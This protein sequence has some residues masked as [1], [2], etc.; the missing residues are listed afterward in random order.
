MN[1]KTILLF[2]LIFCQTSLLMAQNPDSN[3]GD[4]D[5]DPEEIDIVK[6]FEPTLADAVK[7]EFSPDL[8]TPEEIKQNQPVFGNYQVPNRFLTIAYQPP[9]LKPMAYQP[10]S[11]GKNEGEDLHNAWIRA[12]FGTQSTPVL[13]IAL[14]TGKSDKFVVGANGSHISSKG[15]LDF[16]DYSRTKVGVY[17]KTFTDEAFF[18]G[19][20]DFNRSQFYH[21][22]YD[23]TDTTIVFT[24][25][26]LKQQ[27]NKISVR[28]EMGNTTETRSE[29]DYHAEVGFHN[30]R[31]TN[32]EV[33]EN[34]F[35]IKGEAE[36]PMND[37][38]LMGGD[39]FLHYNNVDD[40]DT[41]SVGNVVVNLVPQ[42]TYLA[43]FGRFAVGSNLSFDDN[44]L[45]ALPYIDLEAYL[46]PNKLT[47]YGG[48]QQEFV[49]NSYM[50]ITE[51]NPFVM[52]FISLENTLKEERFIGA[53]G[54]VNNI[55]YNLKVRQELA[56]NQP[57][58]VND[59]IDGRTFQVIYET[60]LKTFNPQ[61]EV[62]YQ[63]GETLLTSLGFNV[64]SYTLEDEAEAWHL[65]SARVNLKAELKPIDNLSVMGELFIINGMKGRLADGTAQD[66][67]NYTDLNFA[68]K[69]QLFDNLSVFA[70]VNNAL[71]IKA[72]RYLNY[73][74]YGLNVLGGAI[75]KF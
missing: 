69:Y 55:S 71:G 25:D 45:S 54:A 9:T 51:D 27:F 65:P 52:P 35:I 66:L 3:D 59:S 8:P 73:P 48:W 34:N 49:K 58:Y 64:Y 31:N 61:V 57:L 24:E 23:Q 68:A 41:S 18:G 6:P 43:D 10:D 70:N 62:S 28:G 63:L 5:I 17:G 11:K 53:K 60:L 36:M 40:T 19:N 30:Y 12:G 13:D 47:V 2:L 22:G 74:T 50:S 75:L 21:Y 72:E 14:S 46:V 38:W 29:L 32:F 1:H 39:V 16:Q 15:S 42:F 67:K 7:V 37:D 56:S 44:D 4:L 26:D 20:I 33:T